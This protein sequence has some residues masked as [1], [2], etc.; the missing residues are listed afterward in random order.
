MAMVDRLT[1]TATGL[2]GV[3]KSMGSNVTDAAGCAVDYVRRRGLRR[4]GRDVSRYV[5][6]NPVQAMVALTAFGFLSGLLARRR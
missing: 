3:A 5:S 6:R 4:I 2:G 1:E